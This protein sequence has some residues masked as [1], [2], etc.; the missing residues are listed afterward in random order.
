LAVS[1]AP[2]LEPSAF[3]ALTETIDVADAPAVHPPTVINVAEVL[4]VSDAPGLEPSVFIALTETIGVVDAPALTPPAVIN[5]AELIA[6]ADVPGVF[7]PV[8]LTVSEAITVLDDVGAQS[9]VSITVSESIMVTDVSQ[10]RGPAIVAVTE[11]IMVFDAPGVFPP[12]VIEIGETIVVADAFSVPFPIMDSD[13]DGILNEVDLDPYTPSAEFSDGDPTLETTGVIMSRG[14]LTLGIRDALDP[15]MGVR[16]EVLAAEG[17]VGSRTVISDFGDQTQGPLGEGGAGAVAVEMS[18]DILVVDRDAGTSRLGIL[19][20]V[21]PSTGLRAVVS[22]FGDETQGPLAGGAASGLA[23]DASGEVLVVDGQ[24][25]TS[26]RGALFLVNPSTGFRT[27]LSDFGDR[28]QGPFGEGGASGVVLE[29]S[30]DILVTDSQAGTNQ[31]GALFGISP[32]TGSRTIVSD[33]GDGTQGPFGEGGASGVTVEASGNL[34]VTDGNAGTSG[35]GALF[36]VSPSTGLRTLVSDFGDGTQGPVGEG[37]ASGLVADSAGGILLVDA[38]A[39]TDL[40]GAL[41]RVNPSSGARVSTSDFGN[42]TQ[43]TLGEGAASGL[44]IDANEDTF[45]VD[46]NA[47][48]S[49]RGNL[50]KVFFPRPAALSV[51]GNSAEIRLS[52]DDVFLVTCTSVT[53]D[54]INGEVAA[55]FF[56]NDGTTATTTLGTGMSV[57][58]DPIDSTFAAPPSN[59]EVVAVLVGAM[60]LEVYPG[61]SVRRV[62]AD[63]KPGSTTNPIN[64]F[65]RGMIPVTIL[66]SDTFDVADVDVT[67]LAFGPDGAA[68]AHEKGGHA[69]NVNDDDFMDLVSHYRTQETGI[70]PGQL[71]ACVTG[72][73][74]DWARFKGCDTIFAFARM[75]GV[76][77]GGN[78][79]ITLDGVSITVVTDDGDSAE[80]VLVNLAAAINGDATLQ[81]LGTTAIADGNELI[82]TGSIS[83]VRIEDTG[84]TYGGANTAVPSLSDP[85]IVSL[86]VL[87]A[88]LGTLLLRHGRRRT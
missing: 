15:L 10:V 35:R 38:H 45:T 13:G 14:D 67:T 2:G 59:E 11:A 7:P 49:L 50:I 20:R 69:E 74:L 57:A 40:R 43:G 81:S 30:G 63:I 28:I 48:T 82:T 84:L 75:F 6:V 62:N 23:L 80:Q 79:S 51:C 9:S 55:E 37:A 42:A 66:G 36:R 78:V 31:R 87:M 33:F 72:E 58:F 3:I 53:I 47:G 4:A 26:A 88:A 60:Q 27:L 65:S 18:G 68:P 21:N 61:E 76:T 83:D 70:V 5:V 29:A 77:R 86:G 73:M 46:G 25:G 1:D 56:G 41:F 32:S 34:L 24:G 71:E 12:V 19:F 16:V 52:I 54:V 39:G 22:D 17:A 64:L 85:A 44:A 8:S